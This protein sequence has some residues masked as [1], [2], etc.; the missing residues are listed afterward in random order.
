MLER[1]VARRLNT[2]KFRFVLQLLQSAQLTYESLFKHCLSWYFCSSSIVGV[3]KE[4][5]ISLP[6]ENCLLFSC[7]MA[8][9]LQ[10]FCTAVHHM[11][12]TSPSVHPASQAL[13]LNIPQP[14]LR[15]QVFLSSPS[16]PA[17]RLKG[18]Y[19]LNA[20]CLADVWWRSFVS[21][22]LS[23]S[24]CLCVCVCVLACTGLFFPAIWIV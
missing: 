18:Q 15:L 12:W 2:R 1:L 16:H 20:V 14:T 21:V 23:Q 10:S 9:A 3:N 4:T 7:S 5:H 6:A 22:C 24:V 17:P 8:A 11:Y 19:G 13:N